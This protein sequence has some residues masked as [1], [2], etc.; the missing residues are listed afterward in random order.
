MKKLLLMVING[1]MVS[2]MA[3]ANIILNERLA[4]KI[5]P[6]SNLST[7]SCRVDVGGYPDFS[8]RTYIAGITLNAQLKL[9]GGGYDPQYPLKLNVD[10]LQYSTDKFKSCEDL[11]YFLTSRVD[12]DYEGTRTMEQSYVQFGGSPIQCIRTITERVLINIPR[13]GIVLKG[14]NYFKFESVPMSRCLNR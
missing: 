12:W 9:N 6:G 7:Y 10:S 8:N 14:S 4:G 1:V 5:T 11:K 3:N 2:S 13:A